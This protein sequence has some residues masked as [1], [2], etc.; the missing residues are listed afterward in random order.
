M[1]LD[2]GLLIVGV[3]ILIKW[4]LEDVC[5]EFQYGECVFYVVIIG[6]F[7]VCF[8]DWCVVLEEFLLNLYW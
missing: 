5:V 2:K 7:G 6:V 3:F 1:Y 4:M 8:I